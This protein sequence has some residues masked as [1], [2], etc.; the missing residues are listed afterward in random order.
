MKCRIIGLEKQE[1]EDTYG[2]LF[3]SLPIKAIALHTQPLKN[4]TSA[5]AQ[6]QLVCVKQER[7]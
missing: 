6:I 3:I 4:N 5:T 1:V 7:C 2:V